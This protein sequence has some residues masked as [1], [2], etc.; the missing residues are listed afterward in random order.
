MKDPAEKFLTSE[1][2]RQIEAR[3]AEAEKRTSGEI[4]V[5]VVP[6]SYHYPLASVLGTL[7]LSLLLGIAVTFFW[8]SESLWIFLSVFGL[9]FILLHELIKRTP[10]LKRLFVT[11]SDMRAEV[12][13]A[14]ITSF[15]HRNIND[16]VDHTGILIFISLYER[17]VRVVADKGIN[18]KVDQSVWQEIV[19]IIIRGI[20]NRQQASAIASAVDR[21]GDIL[22]SHFPIKADDRNELSNEVIIGQ[23]K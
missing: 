13:E 2:R 14:A 5:M 20:H 17:K 1:G 11:R 21:C 7:F 16:T 12:D 3:V 18:A 23:W 19:D 22:S 15:Y 8:G 4:V 9:S 10:L 6:S